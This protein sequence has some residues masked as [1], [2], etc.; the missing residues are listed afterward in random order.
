MKQ[1]VHNCNGDLLSV[2]MSFLSSM[3][4]RTDLGLCVCRHSAKVQYT[5]N[6]EQLT[7][8]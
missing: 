1:K 3:N 4:F 5:S 2:M 6:N 7:E 8:L